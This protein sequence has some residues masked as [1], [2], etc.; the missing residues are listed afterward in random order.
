MSKIVVIISHLKVENIISFV[1]LIFARTRV[2]YSI[3]NMKPITKLSVSELTTVTIISDDFSLHFTN[4]SLFH[5]RPSIEFSSQRLYDM[6]G[7]AP[8]NE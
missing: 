7:L 5:L 4:L 2:L 3:C 8:Y 1:C 6:P